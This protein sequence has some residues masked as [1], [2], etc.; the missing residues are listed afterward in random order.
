MW[1]ILVLLILKVNS[2][3]ARLN[4][5]Y[6]SKKRELRLTQGSLASA[7]GWES[8]GTVSQHLNG[9]IPISLEAVLKFAEN[10]KCVVSDFSHRLA[11]PLSG[12]GA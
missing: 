8:Q 4:A 3:T 10:L 7:C 1:K 2:P 9:K 6:E 11:E 5:I 12:V